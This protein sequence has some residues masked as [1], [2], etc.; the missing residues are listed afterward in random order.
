M[1]RYKNKVPTDCFLIQVY[2][3]LGSLLAEIFNTPGILISVAFFFSSFFLLY[4]CEV[5]QG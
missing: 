2:F 5:G 4:E 1:D 3:F